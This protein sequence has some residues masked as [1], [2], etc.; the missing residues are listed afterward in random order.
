MSRSDRGHGQS[1]Q[2]IADEQRT[3]ETLDSGMAAK[4]IDDHMLHARLVVGPDSNFWRA[5]PKEFVM[6]VKVT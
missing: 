4:F 5:N 1:A 6:E 2:P 3:W